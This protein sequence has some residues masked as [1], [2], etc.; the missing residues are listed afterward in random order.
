MVKDIT[1]SLI[2]GTWYSHWHFSHYGM[3]WFY[4]IFVSKTSKWNNTLAGRKKCEYMRFMSYSFGKN[5]IFCELSS[6]CSTINTV[7]TLQIGQYTVCSWLLF[8]ID[9]T[10]KK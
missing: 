3:L 2:S 4:F 5:T 1:K 10:V 6:L 8:D 9:A 7:Y